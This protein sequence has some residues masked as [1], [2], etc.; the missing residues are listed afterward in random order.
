M[1]CR[2]IYFHKLN[3]LV[4]VILNTLYSFLPINDS[5]KAFIGFSLHDMDVIVIVLFKFLSLKVFKKK[6]N[7]HS[8][9]TNSCIYVSTAQHS[10]VV[11]TFTK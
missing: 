4:D 10:F 5:T 11:K 6:L 9:V 8:Q 3:C 1:K 7:W 2:K